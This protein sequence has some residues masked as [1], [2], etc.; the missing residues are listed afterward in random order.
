MTYKIVFTQDVPGERDWLYSHFPE[1]QNFQTRY[2]GLWPHHFPID[3]G[4]DTVWEIPA[5]DK[6]DTSNIDCDKI[7]SVYSPDK[8]LNVSR[9]T[10]ST[11][12][13]HN[14]IL[15]GDSPKSPYAQVISIP[16]SGTLM[17]ASILW[18]PGGP[19]KQP[20]GPESLHNNF[21]PSLGGRPTIY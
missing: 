5:E 21:H 2:S 17:L 1:H 14:S 16:R 19:Y 7:L 9:W 18:R 8:E 4:S 3:T 15:F 6:I 20:D 10:D 11:K 13:L 12:V